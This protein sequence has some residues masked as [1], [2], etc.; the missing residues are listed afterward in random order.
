MTTG[1]GSGQE[2]WH[3]LEENSMSTTGMKYALEQKAADMQ[4]G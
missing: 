3:L 4:A 1:W 2:G